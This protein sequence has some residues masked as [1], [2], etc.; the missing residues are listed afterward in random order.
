MVVTMNKWLSRIDTDNFNGQFGGDKVDNVKDK[1]ALSTMSP[2]IS[3]TKDKKSYIQ[4]C[5]EEKLKNL[6]KKISDYY[7][8]DDTQ[9]LLDYIDDVIKEWSHDL[10]RA[11]A[12]FHN[13]TMQIT[14]T[15]SKL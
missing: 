4:R 14:A 7:G 13:L 2:S 1:L 3:C 5:K 10:D 11:I 9:F 8:S 6:I 12:C 15:R